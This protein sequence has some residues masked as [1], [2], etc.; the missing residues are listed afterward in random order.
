MTCFFL[1]IIMGSTH[2]RAPAGFAPL[3]IGLGL[4]LIHLISIPVTNTS[5]NPARSTG[6]ALIVGGLGL[7]AAVD[8]LGGADHRRD[9]RR[10]PLS[11]AVAGGRATPGHQGRLTGIG[12]L[13]GPVFRRAGRA[14]GERPACRY[15]ARQRWRR[16]KHPSPSGARRACS[17]KRPTASMKW[18]R[19]SIAFAGFTASSGSKS[20]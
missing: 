18:S 5:V 6:P 7:A 2:S 12:L 4:T 17:A 9:N 14:V 19:R 15:R 11:L 13:P 20:R 16:L 1:L 10:R 8:I 3:A